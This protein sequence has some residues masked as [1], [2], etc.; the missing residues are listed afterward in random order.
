MHIFRALHPIARSL[1]GIG[2]QGYP[3]ARIILV[4][5]GVG[6]V[7]LSLL[8]RDYLEPYSTPAGQVML[9]A[10]GGLLAAGAV[11]MDRMSRI[12]LPQRFTPRRPTVTP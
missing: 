4:I 2:R 8:S 11:L 3:S 12:E 6:V 9:L 5:L 10:V 7:A 1:P